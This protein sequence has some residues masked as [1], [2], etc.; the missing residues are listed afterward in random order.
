VSLTIILGPT[1]AGKTLLATVLA[2]NDEREVYANYHINHPHF[3][4]LEPQH[5][6]AINSPALIIIDEA[7][8]WLESRRSTMDLNLFLGY[9][10][11]QKRKR[12]IEFVLTAQLA[13][14]IDSRFRD[15]ADRI[16]IA[17]KTHQ[18]FKYTII[19]PGIAGSKVWKLSTEAASKY[20][21]A[22]DTMEKVDPIDSDMIVNVMPDQSKLIPELDTII[23]DM[24]TKIPLDRWSLAM[25]EAYCLE[26]N[27]PRQY[28][29]MLYGRM[30]AKALEQAYA[31]KTNQ[32]KRSYKKS[33]SGSRKADTKG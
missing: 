25:V 5:L 14:S 16:I 24:T 10:M 21:G 33:D 32:K 11:F 30:K 7:Y 23:Q 29:K 1:G 26:H 22:Y 27:H 4:A 31:G 17:E 8:A 18:G 2:M 19:R 3:H 13:G 20:Y 28:A 9:V 15:M 6:V 12:Q